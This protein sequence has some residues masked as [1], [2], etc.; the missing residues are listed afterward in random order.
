MIS[1]LFLSGSAAIVDD[2]CVINKSS[3]V[4]TVYCPLSG[5]TVN[6]RR[7]LPDIHEDIH[8]FGTSISVWCGVQPTNRV[9]SDKRGNIRCALLEKHV[10]SCVGKRVCLGTRVRKK[11]KNNYRKKYDTRIV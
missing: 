3:N 9:T 8:S 11:K 1:S 2:K 6:V 10:Y 7:S 4:A 5:K